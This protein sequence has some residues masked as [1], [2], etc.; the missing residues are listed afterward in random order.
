VAVHREVSPP[1]SQASRN[2]TA[3]CQRPS[4]AAADGGSSSGH[5]DD[6][7][8]PSGDGFAESLFYAHP[9]SDAAAAS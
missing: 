3:V 9:R 5:H 8:S 7:A 6:G 2:P 1:V 4:V